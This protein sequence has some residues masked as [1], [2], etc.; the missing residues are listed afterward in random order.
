MEECE[1]KYIENNEVTNNILRLKDLGNKIIE[2]NRLIESFREERKRIEK[3]LYYTCE[4]E[5]VY[6][7]SAC[8]DDKCKYYCKICGC[9]DNEYLY[10]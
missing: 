6:D 1:E 8:F 7:N 5:W 2:Y 3:E 4:H 10:I 9:Y